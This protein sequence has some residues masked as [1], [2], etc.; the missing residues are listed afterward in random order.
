MN[1]NTNSI[2]K[3]YNPLINLFK[4]IKMNKI[5]YGIAF[6][7]GMLGIGAAMMIASY[8]LND[9]NN[10]ALLRY[11]GIVLGLFGFAA[12]LIVYPWVIDEDNKAKNKELDKNSVN[13]LELAITELTKE[14]KNQ[15]CQFKAALKEDRDEQR[16]KEIYEDKY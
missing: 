14:L 3:L 12:M 11:S 4:R 7:M 1:N 15:K 9:G 13:Q 5:Q 16:K 8:A 2:Q 10:E 6:G